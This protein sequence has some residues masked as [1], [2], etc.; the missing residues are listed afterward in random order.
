MEQPKIPQA[1]TISAGHIVAAVVY[2]DKRQQT[3]IEAYGKLNAKFIN[4]LI[5][6]AK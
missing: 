3:R 6:P 5:R 2:G 4:A 1:Q